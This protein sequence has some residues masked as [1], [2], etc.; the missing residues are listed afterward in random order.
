MFNKLRNFKNFN[1]FCYC[2]KARYNDTVLLP[3]TEF[4]LRLSQKK[5]QDRDQHIYTAGGFEDLYDWQRGHLSEPEF[6]LHDGPP[7]ANGPPHMGHAI[8]K[9]LKDAIV[10][11]EI[12]NNKKVHYVP[13]W[14]C[15]GLPIELK[16]L[17]DAD[18]KGL[19]PIELRAKARKFADKSI[20]DQK[21]V[22]KSWGVTANWKKYYTTHSTDYVKCQLRQFLKLYQ[23]NYIF[24]D[25]KPVHWSPSSRTA[26]AEAELEYNENH[27]SPSLHFTVRIKSLPKLG[28][29]NKNYYAILWTTTPWTIPSNQAV[30]Y[31]P[32]LSYSIV[33]IPQLQE[34]AV[35]VIATDLVKEVS[36]ILNTPIETV[37]EIKGSALEGATYEHPLY[38]SDKNDL[39]FVQAEH[40]SSSKG[41][42]L[43]HSAGAH[44]PDDYLVAL[45]NKFSIVDLVDD[46]GCFTTEAGSKFAGKYVL[47]AGNAAVLE[48][49]KEDSSL[50]RL[51]DITH[52]Y[53]YDW[54]TKQPVIIKASRQWFIDTDSIKR[55]AVES[56][57]N[58]RFLPSDK[59][60]LHKSNLI[61]QIEKRPY[62]CI[63]RQRKWGVPIPVLYD[64]TTSEP[65]INENTINHHLN[66]LDTVGV[67]FWWKCTAEQLLPTDS[68]SSSSYNANDVV[69]SED[70]MDI[71]LD[72]GLSW[73]KVL[74]GSKTADVYLEGVDQLTG[75][76]QSSLLTSVALRDKAPFKT[77]YVH[78][79]AVDAK[80]AKMSKSLGNVVDPVEVVLGSR[81][82]PG[83]GVDALRWW[84][85]CHANRDLQASVGDKVLR[86]CCD[87]VQKIRSVLRFAVAGLSDFNSARIE[88][89]PLQH[90]Q[91]IDRY[92]MHLLHRF[93]T[94][95]ADCMSEYQ[96]H[97]IS[98]LLNNLLTNSV[99]ALYY[100]S[101]K[102]RLYCE[103]AESPA[104]RSAQYT[105]YH[106]YETVSLAVA[107]MLPHLVEELHLHSRTKEAKTY[108][109]ACHRRVGDEWLNDDVEG[110][111]RMI[112]DWKREVNVEVGANTGDLDVEVVVSK[113]IAG[114][115]KKNI[116]LHELGGQLI[117]VF[118]VAGI[119]VKEDPEY[120]PDAHKL[121]L[122]KS[123]KHF[124]P[125]CRKV[126]SL[127]ENRL[128]CRCDNVV[129]NTVRK[130]FVN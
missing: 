102:D 101:I 105:L 108:F 98:G 11:Y 71:W 59:S 48:A 115:I 34:D 92:L 84:V 38:K 4:P 44:G 36:A 99:S 76:F 26:L 70:I 69:K 33:K 9:I 104:R 5:L 37:D 15:H 125:R 55:R 89:Q 62:W 91:L 63:S 50:L 49:L 57:E 120:A 113:E 129:A 123:C 107:P 24:R 13:G 119:S 82:K 2:T 7:Y 18:A 32:S 95:V 97:K 77:V 31:N 39:K 20:E 60:D 47:E 90:L 93:Q 66:L 80:G 94:K 52:S 114:R 65:I 3:K 117:D 46:A 10:R 67:D 41:T 14:D 127:E 106:V 16:A 73:A 81:G 100:T 58:V 96:F 1:T 111:F 53:P 110:L 116:D 118:Q 12:L 78:G 86:A 45:R 79:F 56:L 130:S 21:Q 72:S 85:T 75:W 124:C 61:K 6:V 28:P 64:K 27:K 74:D 19:E 83:L 17:K 43:V 68:N 30:C 42:G 23:K 109:T 22:F 103:P 128:C 122:N 121:R 8:N 88:N 29:L 25:V 51:G 112:L 40:V 54:R 35:Y 87:E 126:S